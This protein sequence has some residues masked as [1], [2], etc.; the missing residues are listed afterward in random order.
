MSPKRRLHLSQSL[1]CTHVKFSTTAASP[2]ASGTDRLVDL[3]TPP[4]RPLAP[5]PPRDG[6]P[7]AAA[8]VKRFR[9]EA[10]RPDG[11]ARERVEDRAD[12]AADRT[13]AAAVDLPLRLLLFQK[14]RGEEGV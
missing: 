8:S 10:L 5:P 12:G 3:L 1:H 4:A 9:A 14:A 13:A 2:S 6:F 11:P 7:A